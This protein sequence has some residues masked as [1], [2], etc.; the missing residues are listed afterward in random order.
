M[1]EI[2]GLQVAFVYVVS[3]FRS[4][5]S[6]SFTFIIHLLYLQRGGRRVI[7]VDRCTSCMQETEG[8]VRTST[9]KEMCRI[10]WWPEH[11]G[12]GEVWRTAANRAASSVD[13]PRPLVR[14]KGHVEAV[15]CWRRKF[16]VYIAIVIFWPASTEPWALN[17]EVVKKIDH[18]LQQASRLWTCSETFTSDSPWLTV[19][20]GGMM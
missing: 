14:P 16:T 12:Q 17:I 15:S 2:S 9:G 19:I 8:H 1:W 13:W 7:D 3:D 18:W 10:R 5:S 11:A 20:I 6:C 4:L